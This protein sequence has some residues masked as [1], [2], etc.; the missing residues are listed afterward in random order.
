[1]GIQHGL[2]GGVGMVAEFLPET[3]WDDWAACRCP[4]LT[5][6]WMC[7]V[8]PR[9]GEGELP[10]HPRWEGWS[11]DVGVVV[12]LLWLPAAMGRQHVPLWRCWKMVAVLG[13]SWRWEWAV[14]QPKKPNK[15]GGWEGGRWWAHALR[16]VLEH[17]RFPRLWVQDLSC[18]EAGR[19]RGWWLCR[20]RLSAFGPEDAKKVVAPRAGTVQKEE[21]FVLQALDCW[22]AW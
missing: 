9:R 13:R 2:A 4:S 20:K 15:Q 21:P 7:L 19:G 10:V 12:V 18:P 22:Y 17:V 16:G 5:E 6:G 1:M 3:A 11:R 14:C 8:G